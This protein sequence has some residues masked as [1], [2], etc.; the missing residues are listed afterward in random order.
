MS[1]ALEI[2]VPSPGTVTRE[3]F[4]GYVEAEILRSC[5]PQVPCSSARE[6]LTAF[7]DR[8]GPDKAMRV[9][10]LAFGAQQGFW[11]GAPVTPL[12]FAEAQDW[13]FARPLL[14]GAP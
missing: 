9:C 12:R 3:S 11:R 13:Y 6:V 7:W 1:Q 8:L 10:A 4:P 2:A 5:G 14:E